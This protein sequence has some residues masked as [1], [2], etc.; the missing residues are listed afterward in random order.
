[1]TKYKF[2]NI[3]IKAIAGIFLILIIGL[4]I[5]FSIATKVTANIDSYEYNLP[6]KEGSKYTVAQGYGGFFS[7]S[8]IAAIDFD[9]P[10]GT[11]VYAAR[12]GTIYGYKDDS[13]EGGISSSFK[14]KANYIIVQHADGSF[15]C[16][17]HL[18]KNGVLF[19]SGNVLKGQQIGISGATGFVLRP[20]LHF[21]VK[22][23]L[24]YQMDAFRKTKFKTTMGLVFL[25]MGKVYERPV[26]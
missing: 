23:K 3:I 6:F 7:H 25:E 12:E 15:G 8:H 11:P 1:M 19:K 18:Q 10:E 2:L 17:W 5:F 22:A 4:C 24:N 16:Y 9:M 21:S 26:N 13:N 14:P 20:H